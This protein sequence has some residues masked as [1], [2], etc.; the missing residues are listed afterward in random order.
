M[1]EH[2]VEIV[3]KVRSE[4]KQEFDDLGRRIQYMRLP[5]EQAQQEL[6]LRKHQ[7][8]IYA[9]LEQNEAA[10]H[11]MTRR[12]WMR[13]GSEASY[14]L[15]MIAGKS[16]E[17]GKGLAQMTG[18]ATQLGET[19]LFGGAVGVAIGVIGLGISAVVGKVQEMEAES[20]KAAESW[21]QIR[22]EI[23]ALA[24][25]KGVDKLAQDLGVTREAVEQYVRSG[26]GASALTLAYADAS[27]ELAKKKNELAQSEK[28][29]VDL[30]AS[31]P[32]AIDADQYVTWSSNVEQT[33]ARIAALSSEIGQLNT[34]LSS[35]GAAISG[36]ATR[37]DELKR[38]VDAYP[39]SVAQARAEN[40]AYRKSLADLNSAQQ[41]NIAEFAKERSKIE[42]SALKQREQSEADFAKRLN[43]M[44]RQESRQD[45]ETYRSYAKS[46]ASIQ[47]SITKT[48]QDAN[49]NRERSFMDMLRRIQDAD[50]Q[51]GLRMQDAST[52]RERD[53]IDLERVINQAGL[54]RDA[55]ERSRDLSEQVTEQ[56][57]AAEERRREL[58][59]EFGYRQQLREEDRQYTLAQMQEESAE[60]RNAI[61]TQRAE[62]LTAVA[63]RE[64]KASTEHNLSLM[65]IAAEH[66]A[67][68]ASFTDTRTAAQKFSEDIAALAGTAYD[69][70]IAKIQEM[71]REWEDF[72]RKAK[73]WTPSGGNPWV[74]VT[75]GGDQLADEAW[76]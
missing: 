35:S 47:D 73:G 40:D 72:E 11:G 64:E 26:T 46:I 42:D 65:R 76:R 18:I 45:A 68:V 31:E 17:A 41:K 54:Q 61:A 58:D 75:G 16:G 34:T 37:F 30:L 25:L 48:V 3:I 67:K 71:K 21:T 8:T 23:E 52:E 1:A 22:Q 27:G 44:A 66:R 15:T 24:P 14:Y 50:T 69:P 7:E 9:R 53:R 12:E 28:Y 59:E 13:T 39:A 62:Q 33:R 36:N 29:L 56:L 19:A 6:A 38:A 60:R 32:S 51:Y 10:R 4:G 2:P 20:R 63:E 70:W 49:R 74:R 5:V 57:S 55:S 43:Q